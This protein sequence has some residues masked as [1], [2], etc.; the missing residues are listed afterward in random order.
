[1]REPSYKQIK[2]NKKNKEN[3][4]L[5]PKTP[6]QNRGR[7]ELHNDASK[8]VTTERVTVTETETIKGFHPEPY[9]ER[10]PTTTPPRG[11]RYPQASPSFGVE[12]L[13]FRP[14]K[15]SHPARYLRP[16]NVSES[17]FQNAIWELT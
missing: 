8:K 10:V 11:L 6:E 5:P 16:S 1:M 13:S 17:G 14:E 12:T 2:I 9:V 3:Q 4:N 7:P 15:P